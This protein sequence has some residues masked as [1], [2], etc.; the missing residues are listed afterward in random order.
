MTILWAFVKKI[1]TFLFNKFIRLIARCKVLLLT[2]K[3]SG[4]RK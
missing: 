1:N 2:F 4:L 3:Y